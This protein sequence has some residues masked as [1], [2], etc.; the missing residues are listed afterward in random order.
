MLLQHGAP[1]VRQL[2]VVGHQI[3]CLVE[4]IGD[5]G[6]DAA[7]RGVVDESRDRCARRQGR[8][9][10]DQGRLFRRKVV[11]K[12]A[13]RDVGDS[14]DLINGEA[15]KA[16]VAHDRDCRQLNRATRGNPFALTQAK[17]DGLDTHD[18]NCCTQCKNAVMGLALWVSCGHRAVDEVVID[19]VGDAVGAILVV[20]RVTLTLVAHEV[21]VV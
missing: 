9:V 6:E 11:E 7:A 13:R 3:A 20:G 12:G 5:A 10:A 1:K 21:T 17:L 2:V 16:A 15:V 19:H 4:Q 8:R 18:I 14:T